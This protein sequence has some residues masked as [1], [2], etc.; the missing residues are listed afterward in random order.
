MVCLTVL[1]A[2]RLYLPYLSAL[3]NEYHVIQLYTNPW[4]CFILSPPG[5]AVLEIV[6]SR[7]AMISHPGTFWAVS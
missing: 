7:Q 1:R 4:V 3:K 2:L 6:G 5:G